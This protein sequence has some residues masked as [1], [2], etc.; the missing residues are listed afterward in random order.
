MLKYMIKRLLTITTATVLLTAPIYVSAIA[1]A[2]GTLN[3]T[4]VSDII[5]NGLIAGSNF[6][7][8]QAFPTT[9]ST[10]SPTS[11]TMS[12][13]VTSTPAPM[14]TPATP[15]T[16]AH[17]GT[18]VALGD[19]VAAGLGLA[20][21]AN[22]SN[23]DLACGVSPQAYP[24]VVSRVIKMPFV[25]AACSGAT[26]NNL[27]SAQSIN[28]QVVR[29][30]LDTAFSSGTPS[31]ISI[32]AGAND[33]HWRQFITTCVT[34][35][36]GGAVQTVLAN[37]FLVN[38]QIRMRAELQQINMRSHGNPPLTLVTGYY[39]PISANCSML[40]AN[41]TPAEVSWIAAEVVALNNTI[42]DSTADFSFARYVPVTFQGHSICDATPWVQGLSD[43]APIHPTVVGQ[44][45][46]AFV[47]LVG[48]NQA[49]AAGF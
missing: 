3:D 20:S 13:P 18:Y 46:L 31:L 26:I 32:T 44:N 24:A 16:T 2:Q 47:M 34:G 42:K 43:P 4:S 38:V 14:V 41:I 48:F 27:S 33:A 12:T 6:D 45:A 49:T 10:S 29:P 40:D 39:D 28:G 8:S 15:L 25:N 37:A 19:S 22:P 30:Q 21:S 11:S 5:A 17:N 23:T 1:N 7:I 9:T 36:C 35:T